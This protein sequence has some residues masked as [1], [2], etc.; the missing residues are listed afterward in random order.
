MPVQARLPGKIWVSL[1]R[2]GRYYNQVPL[3]LRLARDRGLNRSMN[4]TIFTPSNLPIVADR[5]SLMYGAGKDGWR[6]VCRSKRC[7]LPNLVMPEIGSAAQAQRSRSPVV[8]R[9]VLP[10]L[11]KLQG[12]AKPGTINGETH[13]VRRNP[14]E[15]QYKGAEILVT[16]MKC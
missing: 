2:A 7:I 16:I 12:R 3:G 1:A 6:L 8:Q 13:R 9:P 15:P 5:T 10:H 4:E 14:Y 11:S